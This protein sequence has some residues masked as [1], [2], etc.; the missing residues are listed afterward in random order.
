MGGHG[1]HLAI[2]V[3]VRV[4]VSGSGSGSVRV[5]LTHFQCEQLHLGFFRS[6]MLHVCC[7]M[8]GQHANVTSI[9]QLH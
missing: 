2:K 7:A 6:R 9:T 5:R 3:R 4:R 1:G 8:T